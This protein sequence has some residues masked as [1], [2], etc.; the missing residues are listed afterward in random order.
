MV[1]ISS[2]Q[3][4][5]ELLEALKVHKIV[6]GKIAEY[7]DKRQTRHGDAPSFIKQV[8]DIPKPKSMKTLLM[9]TKAPRNSIISSR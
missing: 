3:L 5:L 7:Q 2:A 1:V 8:A 9:E 6:S 4:N